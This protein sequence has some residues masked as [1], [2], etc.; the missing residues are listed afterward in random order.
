MELLVLGT[1]ALVIGFALGEGIGQ[2]IGWIRND[3]LSSTL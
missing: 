2:M 3:D 1:V